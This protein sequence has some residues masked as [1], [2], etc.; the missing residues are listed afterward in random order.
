M[1]NTGTELITLFLLPQAEFQQNACQERWCLEICLSEDIH[2]KADVREI[3]LLRLR[4]WKSNQSKCP[5]PISHRFRGLEITRSIKP[6]LLH[7]L[8]CR[9]SQ[10]GSK[11]SNLSMWIFNDFLI[12]NICHGWACSSW[13]QLAPVR[14]QLCVTL[15]SVQWGTPAKAGSPGFLALF[16]IFWIKPAPRSGTGDSLCPVTLKAL[17]N[18]ATNANLPGLPLH[19]A[20]AWPCRSI[21]HPPQELLP[22]YA[23]SSRKNIRSFKSQ[24]L[25]NEPRATINAHWSAFA[26][27][28]YSISNTG[29]LHLSPCFSS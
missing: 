11:Q 4:K 8:E 12:A 16:S 14:V 25:R 29:I 20:G 2:A 13:S 9:V 23:C 18:T 17:Q 24:E 10:T 19:C 21:Y 28:D 1:I 7:R 3:I 26:L 6:K 5:S 22:T 27:F 15:R